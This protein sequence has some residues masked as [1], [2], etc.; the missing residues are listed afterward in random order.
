M[1]VLT[2]GKFIDDL[3]A[4]L[5]S[6]EHNSCLIDAR[7][8]KEVSGIEL[9]SLLKRCSSYLKQNGVADGG[10][11]V[12][13]LPNSIEKIILFLTCATQG[14]GFVPLE[15]SA[16]QR[17]VINACN[18]FSPDI[19]IQITDVNCVL[20]SEYLNKHRVVALS[21]NL[22]EWLPESKDEIFSDNRKAGKLYI[23]TS[24]STG[25]PKFMQIDCETLWG[26]AKAFTNFHSDLVKE[27]RFY[28][29]MPMAYLGGLFNLCLI[30]LSVSASIV[31]AAPNSATN[32]LNF[33][34]DVIRYNVGV[35]WLTPT[36]VRSLIKIFKP[37]WT[38]RDSA[39]LTLRV[40]FL[41]TAPISLKEKKEFESIFDVMLLENY[42]LSETTFITSE[43]PESREFRLE[44]SVGEVLP[45]VEVR[46][47]ETLDD[48]G[49][50][51]RI[52]V[53]SDFLMDG[54]L[55]DGK[56]FDFIN[57]NSWFDTADAGYISK[58][59]LLLSGRL[60]DIIKK[61]GVF[62]NLAE[63][64]FL[65]RQM[66]EVLDAACL[67]IEHDFYGEDY[68]LFIVVETERVSQNNDVIETVREHLGNTL[69]QSKWPTE[70]YL[71]D[72][73]P[74]TKSGKVSKPGLLKLL[75]DLNE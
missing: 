73:I 1:K 33:W 26:S 4:I 67:A 29:N 74:K 39:N 17:E 47:E 60:R 53:K 65:V 11:V 44:G 49:H 18:S 46:L 37:R 14:F 34:Q 68:I 58:G 35:I 28:N 5:L 66:H 55:L 71:V 25:N 24:G 20:P 64:E 45:W 69:V 23:S 56:K 32:V 48:S 27:T 30:P 6:M 59:T 50:Y 38:E 8:G 15:A 72:A 42:A 10:N 70:I 3:Q 22:F 63:A 2:Q 36:M 16:S 7:S 61:G 21:G 9:F 31:V 13:M 19:V 52:L 43:T 75:E 41:G 51:S 12:C 57:K 62:V 40:G 54:Y